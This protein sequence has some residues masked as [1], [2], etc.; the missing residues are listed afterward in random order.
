[1]HNDIRTDSEKVINGR[2]PHRINLRGLFSVYDKFDK[3]VSVSPAT[4]ELNKS[5]LA[6]FAE[7]FKFD[8]V[9]NSINPEKILRLGNEDSSQSITKALIH[10][11]LE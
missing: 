5:N 11:A 6:E 10:E 7:E 9:M 4:M 2:R 1:M 3:L 8:F